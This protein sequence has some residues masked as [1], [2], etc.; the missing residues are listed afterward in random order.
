M[1]GRV[2]LSCRELKALVVLISQVCITG[3]VTESLPFFSQVV[4]DGEACS[5]GGEVKVRVGVST[6]RGDG[7]DSGSAALGNLSWYLGRKL[8]LAA[9]GMEVAGEVLTDGAFALIMHDG[10]RAPWS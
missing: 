10:K 5:V 2:D 6:T 3:E 9:G 4:I 8:F 1:H 7:F